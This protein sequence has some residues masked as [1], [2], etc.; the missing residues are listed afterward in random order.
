MVSHTKYRHCVVDGC[1]IGIRT[2]GRLLSHRWLTVA[3]FSGRTCKHGLD[4]VSGVITVFIAPFGEMQASFPDVQVVGPW[5]GI[6]TRGEKCFLMMH[7]CNK[8]NGCFSVWRGV[9]VLPAFLLSWRSFQIVVPF[10]VLLSKHCLTNLSTFLTF[11]HK[12]VFFYFVSAEPQ[13]VAYQNCFLYFK[14]A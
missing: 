13:P 9:H 2:I 14:H 5:P 8:C 3:T 1:L 11:F 10:L 4:G 12:L 6:S 7:S